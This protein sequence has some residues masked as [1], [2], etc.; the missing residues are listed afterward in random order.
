MANTIEGVE[1]E[2]KPIDGAEAQLKKMKQMIEVFL[3]L[4]LFV[5]FR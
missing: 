1:K 2:V 5:V 4:C 3:F